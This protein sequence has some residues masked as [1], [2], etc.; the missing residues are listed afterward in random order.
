MSS[1]IHTAV[2]SLGETKRAIVDRLKRVGAATVPELA[3]AL[4]VT[5][6]GVRQHVDA[7]AA[8][9][10]VEAQL[11]GP[12]GRGRPATEWHLTEL[13]ADLFPDR[14]DDLTVG[15]IDALRQSLGEEGLQRV[16]DARAEKQLEEYR[17]AIPEHASL[18]KRVNALAR[19]RTAE[20]YIAEVVR[21]EDGALVLVEHHCPICTAARACQGLCGSELELFRGALGDD[22]EVER[23]QH[24]M[25][26]DVRCAYRVTARN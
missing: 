8:N 18:L 1:E 26:G 4:G 12:S 19:Q 10:L 16:I 24:L 23:T 5:P 17:H 11:R 22:V 20:G 3:D 6:A 14:H 2:P 25:A 21:D 7:L 9:G 15:L 13:A